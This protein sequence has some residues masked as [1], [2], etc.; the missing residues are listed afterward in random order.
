VLSALAAAGRRIPAD[1]AVVSC[2][3]MPFAAYLTPSLTSLRV[4]FAQT[5]ERAVELLLSSI[6]GQDPPAEPVLLPVE[7]II[8]DSSGGPP[9]SR[10][11]PDPAAAPAAGPVVPHPAALTGTEDS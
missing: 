1:V 4:P 9:E 6:A 3:D 8:R 10:P 2:D 11:D 7:R 5:G